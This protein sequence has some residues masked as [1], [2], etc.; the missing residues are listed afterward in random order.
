VWI[1][2]MPRAASMSATESPSAAGATGIGSWFFGAPFLTS[3][4]AYWTPPVLGAVPLASAVVFDLGV[5]LT[6]VGATM[7][8]LASIG[9]LKAP[10]TEAGQ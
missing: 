8:A 6:V 9:R 2:W 4:Y 3:T 10:S 5:F 7:L 1:T